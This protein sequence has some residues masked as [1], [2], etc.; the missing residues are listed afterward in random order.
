M[1]ITLKYLHYAVVVARNQSISKAAQELHLSQS[2]IAAALDT[3]ESE[4][5]VQVFVRHRAKGVGLTPS[6]RAIIARANRILNDIETFKWEVSQ[7]EH[8]LRG[9]L[10]IGCYTPIAPM[11]LPMVIKDFT[12]YYPHVSV[13]LHEGDLTHIQ[14]LLIDGEIDVILTYDLGLRADLVCQTLAVAPIHA[15]LPEGDPLS[16]KAVLRMQDITDRPLIL[17]DLPGYRDY[18]Q[19]LFD[20]SRLSPKI[21]YKTGGYQ[22]VCELVG[23]G[24]GYS[25]L[26]LKPLVDQTY[27]GK[28]LVRRPIDIK[29]QPP[30]LVLAYPPHLTSPNVIE[31][32]IA[33]CKKRIGDYETAYAVYR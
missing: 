7:R 32:F 24:L 16:E 15:V 1:N 9:V 3:L 30:Q 12:E 17:L 14:S 11:L 5:G 20:V 23:A 25:L 8:D 29:M 6:G 22:V 19:T 31:A 33:L 13:H 2:G 4:L 21:L 28:F 18:I 10:H 26:N 27:H